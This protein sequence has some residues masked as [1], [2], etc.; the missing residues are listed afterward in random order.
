MLTP[1]RAACRRLSDEPLE[2]EQSELAIHC[3]MA[4]SRLQELRGDLGAAVKE[5]PSSNAFPITKR[6]K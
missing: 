1:W 3:R 6:L 2:E 5:V 4:L